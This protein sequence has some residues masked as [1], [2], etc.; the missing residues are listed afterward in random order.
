MPLVGPINVIAAQEQK[1]KVKDI[2]DFTEQLKSNLNGA[3]AKCWFT[4][5]FDERI[6]A[7]LVKEGWVPC[8]HPVSTVSELKIDLAQGA[9]ALRASLDKKTR[10]KLRKAE[11]A[12]IEVS[13]SSGDATD[14]EE[15]ATLVEI[16]K[17]RSSSG[18]RSMQQM[19]EAWDLF[20]QHDQLRI[21]KAT[22]DGKVLNAIAVVMTQ[23]TVWNRDSGSLRGFNKLNAPLYLR[24]KIAE[25]Y[26]N[27][28]KRK[29]YNLMGV[30]PKSHRDAGRPHTLDGVTKFKQSFN[31]HISDSLGVFELPLDAKL[32]KRFKTLE[33]WILRYY[34]RIKKEYW[35]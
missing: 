12:G 30:S 16:T 13:M 11:K 25:H 31:P 7:N 1:L 29:T 34:F 8:K 32:Y 35:Y 33:P 24:W 17:D 5:K 2:D 6:A 27:E 23:D 3:V 14:I 26:A 19:R 4:Q 20:K 9:E 22:H 18:V 28:G 10:Y 15:L 21:W